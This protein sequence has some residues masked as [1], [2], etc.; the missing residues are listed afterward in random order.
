[1]LEYVIRFAYGPI[2][3]VSL[4]LLALIAIYRWRYYKPVAYRY[5]LVGYLSAHL[6]S[7]TWPSVLLY[8]MRFISLLI[9]SFLIAKPQIVDMRSKVPV[10]GIDIMLVLDVSGSMMAFDDLDDT[11]SRI[12]VAKKE[13]SKFIKKRP[14]DAIGLVL[15]GKDAV[16]RAPLTLDKNILNSI[17]DEVKIGL[18]NYE[19]TVLAKAVAMA[20]NRLKKSEAS[21]KVIILLTDGAPT[22]EFDIDPNVAIKI[23]QQ[24]GIKIYTVGIGSDHG[25]YI[26]DSFGFLR[27]MGR[28]GAVNK[29]L[30]QKIASATG[31][32]YFAAKNP[33]DM[34]E[35]YNT[36]DA[37]EKTK[38]EAD[39]FNRVYDV[40]VPWVWLVIALLMIEL[41]FATFKWVVI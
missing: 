21:S 26:R 13:A 22:R 20:A 34:A 28:Q 32:R 33:K 3:F 19:A 39:I 24:F 11:R 4:P 5:P 30:L 7:L 37:L 1:M 25:G 23:A 31:G 18:V 12:T 41:I 17:M 6:S 9:L 38:Q 40:F 36:I 10:E 29:P 14:N 2:L 35:I 15:F 8:L 16:V 27:Q